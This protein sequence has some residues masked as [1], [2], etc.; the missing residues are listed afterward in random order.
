MI[1]FL[2]NI[3][4]SWNL[5]R[6]KVIIQNNSILA[7]LSKQKENEKNDH[8]TKQTPVCLVFC[9]LEFGNVIALLIQL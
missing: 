2:N 9:L 1:F 8:N 7:R 6:Q 4:L 3:S 5:S